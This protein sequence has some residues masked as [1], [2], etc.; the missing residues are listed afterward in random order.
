GERTAAWS[1]TIPVAV[2]VLTVWTLHLRPHHTGFLH[3]AV[4]PVAALLVLAATF[5][6]QPV[7]I[8]GLVMVATVAASVIVALRKLR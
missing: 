5:T 3:S 7:L 6:G 8:T 2:Y 4:F 1:L